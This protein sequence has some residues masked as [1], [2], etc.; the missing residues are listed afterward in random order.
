MPASP[1]LRSLYV[2]YLS[3]DDP[4]VRTQVVAYIAGLVERGHV[5]HLLT[6]E[7]SRLTRGRRRAL[8]AEM[9]DLG[10]AWHGLRYHKAPSLPATVFDTFLGAVVSVWLVRRFGLGAVHARSH[11]PVAMALIARRL[12]RFE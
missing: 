12:A 4:L 7:T 9:R 8:R 5:V 10:I 3:L 1:R 6:F 2:C 11:I